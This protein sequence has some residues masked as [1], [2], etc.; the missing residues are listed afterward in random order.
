MPL[1]ANA[2]K[3]LRVSKRK[4]E[5]NARVKSIVKTMV[6]KVK[7]SPSSENLANAYSALDTAVRKHLM[8]KNRA[9][10]VKSQLSKL[11]KPTQK[12]E[13]VVP[14]KAASAKSAKK[15]SEKSAKKTTKAAP[16]KVTAKKTAKK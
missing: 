5:V 1:L 13:K 12:A 10:R 16:K 7:K 15:V 6:D 3:A 4:T 11:A 9:A 8:H 2:K 14:T